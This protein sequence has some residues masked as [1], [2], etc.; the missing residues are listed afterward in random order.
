MVMLNDQR[1]YSS[2]KES[3]CVMINSH[4]RCTQIHLYP[5][6]FPSHFRDYSIPTQ[7][8][9]PTSPSYPHYIWEKIVEIH[10]HEKVGHVRPN[11]AHPN[12]HL[13]PDRGKLGST[14]VFPYNFDRWLVWWLSGLAPYPWHP[15]ARFHSYPI[16][17]ISP[18]KSPVFVAWS[19]LESWLADSSWIPSGLIHPT[20]KVG[21]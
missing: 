21:V 6:Q 9:H 11:S 17:I 16:P 10:Q 5:T 7:R 12:H 3:L 20:R 14:M 1:V 4:F 18:V 19:G 2:F 8:P 15:P 13:H